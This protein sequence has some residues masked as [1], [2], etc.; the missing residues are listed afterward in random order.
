MKKLLIGLSLPLSL[1]SLSLLATPSWA[2]VKGKPVTYQANGVTLN[3]YL[4][5][6]DAAKG[7]RPGV[8]VV[9]EWWGHNEHARER[10]RRL[11]KLGYVAL[12]VD[13][14]GEGKQAR[15]PDEA[16]KFATAVGGDPETAR[17]RFNAALDFLKKQKNVDP[18]HIAAIGFCFGGTVVLQMARAGL[19]L[20]GVVSFHGGLATQ[21][22]AEPGKVHSKVLVLTG[23]DDKMIPPEQVAQFEE[24]MKTAGV[25]YRVVVYP[26]A[27][28][29]FT[30]P[31]ADG[32]AKKFNMPVGYDAKADKASWEEMR[33]FLQEVFAK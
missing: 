27:K 31:A 16:K 32:Y 7:R 10:A 3:G 33:K 21:T 8:L 18:E 25:D 30:N 1:L 20:D 15:H 17:A 11:A 23:A 24:E 6:D 19:D 22:P 14:F 13:M 2:A 28:H 26:G 29:A 5:A 9:H 12:A 4:A